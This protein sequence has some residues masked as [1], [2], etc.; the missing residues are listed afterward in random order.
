MAEKTYRAAVVGCG[1]RGDNHVQAYE[2]ID[3]AECVACCAPSPTRREPMAEKYG[4]TAYADIAEMIRAERPDI[5]HVVTRPDV[6]VEPLTTVDELGVPLCTVEKPL[7]T[8][9]ADWRKLRELEAAANTRF[10]VCHQTR[11]NP[12]LETC[13][14]AVAGGK[15]GRPLMLHLSCG[16]NMAG[17]GTH[18]QNYGLS[19]V[20]D[21]PVVSVFGNARGWDMR[22][23]VHPAPETTVA[24]LTLEGGLQALWTTGTV[25]VRCGN[26]ETVHQHVRAGACFE[27]GRIEWQQFGK[28]QIVCNGDVQSGLCYESPEQFSEN[29]IAEQ[30]DFHR[31][32][33]T[34]LEGGPPAGTNLKRS[35]HEWAVILALY[36]SALERRPVDLAG[37][38]PP[39]DLVEQYK[40][41]VG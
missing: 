2:R 26:A 23:T 10:A 37:F 19:L 31:A 6:R 11:W 34:W 30:A 24:C 1:H 28:W 9:V 29:W 8:G 35:L 3:N 7:A 22:D 40:A 39:E 20:G 18:T 14:Q 21:L 4:L 33:F 5:V 25:S 41:A 13:R 38:D 17:Q 15:L 32:M 12:H 27:N 36:T 16:M